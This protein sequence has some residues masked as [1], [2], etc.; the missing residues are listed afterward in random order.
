MKFLITLLLF[1]SQSYAGQEGGGGMAVKRDSKYILY[2]FIEAGLD[3]ESSIPLTQDK[4]GVTPILKQNLP[5]SQ[6]VLLGLS[7][8]LNIIYERHPAAAEEILRALEQY[9]WQLPSL[10]I[11]NAK[12]IGKTPI[13]LENGITVVPVAIRDDNAKV[14]WVRRSIWDDMNLFNRVG[15]IIHEV[16][17]ALSNVQKKQYNSYGARTV[18]GF[19]FNPMFSYQKFEKINGVFQMVMSTENLL[20]PSQYLYY[21]SED[22]KT[23]CKSNREEASKLLKKASAGFDALIQEAR[24]AEAKAQED[25]D[26]CS[27]SFEEKG[28]KSSLSTYMLD[29]DLLKAPTPPNENNLTSPKRHPYTPAEIV[30][31]YKYYYRTFRFRYG[32]KGCEGAS[33]HLFTVSNEAFTEFKKMTLAANKILE[34]EK[35]LLNRCL[36]PVAT[37]ALT[38]LSLMAVLENGN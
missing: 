21:M 26:Y 22:Y 10:E 25:R 30:R 8:M 17:Y 28:L 31:V 5:F 27:S 23:Q 14:V 32:S 24:L 15:L 35:K 7:S 3:T 38:G 9:V 2:D 29:G 1:V 12:D 34:T 4:M 13:V 6:D 18:N 11:T 37:S 16:L 19:I 33:Q 20:T 36:N